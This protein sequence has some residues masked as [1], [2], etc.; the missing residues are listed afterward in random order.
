MI[1][2]KLSLKV[3][4]DEDGRIYSKK[5]IDWGDEL[6]ED[7]LAVVVYELELIK[8]KILVM[9]GIKDG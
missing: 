1:E 6:S 5:S 9:G 2:L 7:V 8:S 4:K 3:W